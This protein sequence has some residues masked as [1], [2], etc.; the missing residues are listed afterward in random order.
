[1]TR[2]LGFD[3][4]RLREEMVRQQIA[5]RGVRSPA[6]LRAM[7]HVRR[8]GYVP[9]YLGEFAYEDAPLPIEEEQTISQPYIVAFMV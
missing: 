7:R 4:E 5:G 2:P 3:Y 6:V 9:S 1:M 8:E